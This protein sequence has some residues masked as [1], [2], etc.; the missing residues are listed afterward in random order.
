MKKYEST[1]AI[2]LFAAAS[3]GTTEL[4]A[5][6]TK[7]ATAIVGQEVIEK[8]EECR[9]TRSFEYRELSAF[10]ATAELGNALAR[11]LNDKSSRYDLRV[12]DESTLRALWA[13]RQMIDKT[14][15]PYPIYVSEAV[16]W[17][18]KN[19]KKRI[20]PGMLMTSDVLLHVMGRYDDESLS[21]RRANAE[22]DTEADGSGNDGSTED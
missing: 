14:G 13:L 10:E 4:T 1:R 5:V 18:E 6:Q 17:L 20:R 3:K 16:H 15:I 11:Q 9:T 19:G 2:E 7:I 21:W 12:C 22:L 8:D